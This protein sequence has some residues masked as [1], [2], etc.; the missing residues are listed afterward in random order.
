M[1][2]EKLSLVLNEPF[3]EGVS[4]FDQIL[5]A[6]TCRFRIL[7]SYKIIWIIEIFN[8]VISVSVYY[9]L[10][11]QVTSESL[12]LLGYGTS[13]L[14]FALVGISTETFLRGSIQRINLTIRLEMN[15]GTWEPLLVSTMKIHKFFAAQML[16]SFTMGL[17]FF[18]ISFLTGVMVL[19]APVFLNVR[20]VLSFLLFIGLMISSNVGIGIAAAGLVMIFKKG[21]PLLA[22]F[23]G[24]INLLSGVLYPVGMLPGYIQWFSKILPYTYALEAMRKILIFD[25]SVFDP[26]IFYLAG[27]LI[28]FTIVNVAWGTLVFMWC[29]NYCKKKG[30]T[31]QY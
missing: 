26:H 8:A 10:G 11:K 31:G 12:A 28:L 22:I 15:L 21:D 23:T 14:A 9:F 18:T 6:Y 13:Y 24:F 27:V 5:S 16:A 2:H 30:I 7:F 17:L 19:Q 1:N 20:T 29:L 4:P 25:L 3:K